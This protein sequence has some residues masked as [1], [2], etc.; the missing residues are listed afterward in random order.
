MTSIATGDWPSHHAVTGWFTHLPERGLT[1]TTLHMA[2]RFSGVPIT[3]YGLDAR[4]VCPVPAIHPEMSATQLTLLPAAIADTEYARYARGGTAFAPYEDWVGASTKIIE[5]VGAARGATFT[6]LYVPDVDSVCHHHGLNDERVNVLLLELDEL[7]SRLS[8]ALPKDARLVITADHGLISV[9][10]EAH[11]PITGEDYVTSLLSAPPSGDGRMPVFHVR[12]G[13]K[14]EFVAAFA[15]HFDERFALLDSGEAEKLGLFG[16]APMSAVARRRF[17]DYVG[18]ALG[19]V[20]LHYASRR[21]PPP[22]HVYV[23]QHG[24]L[25]REELLIPLIVA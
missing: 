22:Q 11:L 18:I 14:D 16:P 2:E 25:T 15:S 13:R 10:R 8:E 3:Q 5:F 9:K 19:P 12:E 20:I 1:V 7:L 21:G 6:H 24:G 4:V 23:A 17:G